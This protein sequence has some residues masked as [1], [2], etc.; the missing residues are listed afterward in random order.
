[1]TKFIKASEVIT[2]IESLKKEVREEAQRTKLYVYKYAYLYGED[3]IRLFYDK[4]ADGSSIDCFFQSA[5]GRLKNLK[6][7]GSSKFVYI[8]VVELSFDFRDE[9]EYMSLK[10]V[11]KCVEFKGA[12]LDVLGEYKGKTFSF[13][14]YGEEYFDPSRR[15]C[16]APQ[17][18][19]TVTDKKMQAW[20]DYLRAEKAAQ[21]AD[22]NAKKEEVQK[23]KQ[24]LCEITGVSMEVLEGL[25]E[26]TIY[27]DMFRVGWY[28]DEKSG[29]CDLSI[30]MNWN[31]SMDTLRTLKEKGL[32]Y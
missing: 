5:Q 13:C 17:N 14:L 32:L 10:R 23:F 11:E 21:E 29:Y 20:V 27:G 6:L 9:K 18:V 22:K 1:M 2:A 31:H 15:I 28:A 12:I 26:G 24:E 30:R 4:Y 19:G 8:A 3:A 25:E 7:S 16:K